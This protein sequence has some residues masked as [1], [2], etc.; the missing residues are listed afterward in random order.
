[1]TILSVTYCVIIYLSNKQKQLLKNEP[2]EKFHFFKFEKMGDPKI[3]VC[4]K[5]VRDGEVYIFAVFSSFENDTKD[6]LIEKLE[7]LTLF[8][9]RNLG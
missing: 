1:M 3:I 6:D 8:E 2:P 4:N 7:N 9:I 5:F